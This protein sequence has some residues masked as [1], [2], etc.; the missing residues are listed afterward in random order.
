MCVVFPLLV[1]SCGVVCGWVS[2][3]CRVFR[4]GFRVNPGVYG[5]DRDWPVCFV[6]ILFGGPVAP[7]HLCYLFSLGSL[8]LGGAHRFK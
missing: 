1:K 8:G 5:S 7:H 3:G 6:M 4:L 2:R